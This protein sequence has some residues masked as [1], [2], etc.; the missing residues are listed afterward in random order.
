MTRLYEKNKL[1]FALVC[2]AA[3][4]VL[5]SLADGLSQ[6]FGVEKLVTAPVG[7]ALAALLMLWILRRGLGEELGLC[8]F[9]GDARRYLYF[10]PLAVLA[11]CNLWNG[12]HMNFTAGEAALYVISMLFVG[13]IEELIFRG[14]LFTA[15]LR[16]GVRQAVVIS[17]LTFG[18]G[19][20]V[21]L[22]NGAA[23][24]PTLL[25]L[26]YACAVG[27]MFTVLFYKGGSLWPCMITHGVLNALSAFAVEGTAAADM[28][29]AAALTVI[30]VLYALWILK[31]GA[32][33]KTE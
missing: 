23:L 14:F 24:L 33:D 9:K 15:L 2:I 25:Q 29:T 26:V 30:S 8:R 20:I 12:V 4:V 6:Q 10:L 7:A 32:A 5:M 27:F 21:N 19:H 11:S 28:L 1:T 3:Y 16:G 13:V 22:F 31:H 17:S 18:L